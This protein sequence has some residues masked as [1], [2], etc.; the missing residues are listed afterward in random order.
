MDFAGDFMLRFFVYKSNDGEKRLLFWKGASQFLNLCSV[1]KEQSRI[2]RHFNAGTGK[3]TSSPAGT[4][5]TKHIF[6]KAATRQ[7]PFSV[8]PAGLVCN[9]V[10]P[11]GLI[12]VITHILWIFVLAFLICNILN[13]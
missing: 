10:R 12:L 11:R 4:A 13:I 8:V 7:G 2:A 5:E 1:P 6:A 3:K 9:P